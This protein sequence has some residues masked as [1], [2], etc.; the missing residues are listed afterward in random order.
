MDANTIRWE[1]LGVVVGMGGLAIW[2]LA[3]GS[4]EKSAAAALQPPE[5]GL[6]VEVR[7]PGMPT[8]VLIVPDGSLIGRSRECRIVLDDSTVSKQ[9]ARL[10]I[11]E[12]RPYVEDLQSTN[13]TSLNGRFFEHKS[14]LRRG[15]RIGLGTNLIVLVGVAQPVLSRQRL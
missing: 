6:R 2:S 9:H 1:T 10:F 4:A 7:R 12:G 3:A 13:G 14:P 5:L 8:E 11:D 15:D